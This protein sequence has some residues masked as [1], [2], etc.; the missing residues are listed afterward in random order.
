MHKHSMGYLNRASKAIQVVNR[1]YKLSP[2]HHHHCY[3]LGVPYSSSYEHGFCSNSRNSNRK[4]DN[5]AIDLSQYPTEKIRNFSIIAHV[6][7]GKSTLADRL[8][9]LTGTI[10]RGLG[11]QYLDKLQVH[12]AHYHCFRFRIFSY[13]FISSSF[14][15]FLIF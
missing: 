15:D 10:K 1:K 4:D 2:N 9:E 8:L 11:A 3:R 13:Y 14:S 6:D 5:N 7:H 12:N